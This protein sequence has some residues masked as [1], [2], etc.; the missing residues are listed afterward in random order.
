MKSPPTMAWESD[1]AASTLRR[2]LKIGCQTDYVTNFF[3]QK[4]LSIKGETLKH[5]HPNL[6]LKD[7]LFEAF[8]QSCQGTL[9]H[10]GTLPTGTL[11]YKVP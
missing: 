8:L 9:H 6:D 1:T 7:C 2:I 3:C 4:W 10:E 5:A 11:R